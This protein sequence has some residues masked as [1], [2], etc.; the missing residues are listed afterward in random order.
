M[1]KCELRECIIIRKMDIELNYDVGDETMLVR[2]A[3]SRASCRREP[4]VCSLACY[5]EHIVQLCSEQCFLRAL[6][7]N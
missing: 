3:G 5:D 6:I 7:L 1:T 2:G 4:A